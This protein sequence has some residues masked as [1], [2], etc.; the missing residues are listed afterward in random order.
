MADDANCCGEFSGPWCCSSEVGEHA[1]KL[2]FVN[3]VIWCL[4]PAPHCHVY[5]T[6]MDGLVVYC[7]LLTRVDASLIPTKAEYCG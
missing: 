5:E 4:I 2:T 3:Y 7:P 6:N 1:A